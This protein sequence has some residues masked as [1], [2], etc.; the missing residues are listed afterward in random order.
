MIPIKVGSSV[1]CKENNKKGIVME[2]NDKGDFAKVSIDQQVAWYP[3]A[4]LEQDYSLI[5]R[6]LKSQFDDGL[7]F[8]LSIDSYRLL[9][10]Y[11]FNPYVLAS[12]TKIFIFPHQID[13][14]MRVLDNPRM[15]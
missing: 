14:V 9:T 4:D 5:D 7:D 8:I 1:V 6:L 3:V 13:E 2:L 15:I 12:S 10:E 11:R